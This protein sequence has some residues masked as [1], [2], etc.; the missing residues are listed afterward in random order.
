MK[1][2]FYRNNIF[3]CSV[4]SILLVILLLPNTTQ[5][6]QDAKY[7]QYMFNS[8][9]YNPAYAGTIDAV[10]ATAIHREQWIGFEG[11]PQTSTIHVH[12]PV[13]EKFGLG[14]ALQRD[15]LGIHEWYELQGIY[16]YKFYV[17]PKSKISVGLSAS[18]LY[19]NSDY[20][21]ID[22]SG[23]D[24]VF[25]QNVSNILPNFG[26]GIYY[27]SQKHY[28]GFSIPR[29]ITNDYSSTVLS[30]S[31]R[32]YRHFY[33]A[34]G[35]VLPLDK[36]GDFKL[37]PSALAKFVG[38]NAPPQFDIDL[39][40]FIKNAFWVGTSYRTGDSLDFLVGLYLG[41]N[42]RVGYAFDWINTNIQEVTDL[43]SHEVMLGIDFP[44]N[45]QKI[46]TPRYF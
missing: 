11:R 16:S 32:Q 3:F 43:N 46:I 38:A 45:N 4:L 12:G 44:T 1:D 30:S 26:F 6:Q 13:R 22:A 25:S 39:Q 15:R 18:A 37:K 10:S 24:I 2:K 23:T 40:L 9:M 7:T 29:L 5:A 36:K 8:L 27:Y 42:L 20:S 31:A 14:V 35:L 34:G 33:V 19:Q 21:A 17:T 41:R 28:L